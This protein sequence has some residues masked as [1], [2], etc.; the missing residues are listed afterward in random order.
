[1]QVNFT[2]TLIPH[3]RRAFPKFSNMKT[4]ISSRCIL[5]KDHQVPDEWATT[6]VM[7][8]DKAHFLSTVEEGGVSLGRFS[9]SFRETWVLL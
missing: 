1:M 4:S 6:V 3:D 8:S 7:D 5:R 2:A 9:L